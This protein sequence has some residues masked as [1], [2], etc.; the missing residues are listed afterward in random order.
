MQ[1]RVIVV[2]VEKSRIGMVVECQD[3]GLEEGE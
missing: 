3:E 2:Q 1:S